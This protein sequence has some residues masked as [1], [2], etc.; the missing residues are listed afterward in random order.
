M[1]CEHCRQDVPATASHEDGE[2]RCPQC[3]EGLA[4]D[5]ARPSDDGL[6]DRQQPAAA[7]DSLLDDGW[8][9]DQQLQHIERVLKAG[10]VGGRSSQAVGPQEVTRFDPAH[11]G[12]AAW[13]PSLAAKPARNR[14]PDSGRSSSALGVLAWMALSL[15]TTTFACGGML[16][17]WSLVAERQ[18]LWNLGLPIALGGQIVLLIGL[19]LQLDRLWHDNRHAAAKLDQVD[20]QLHDL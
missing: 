2:F 9:L 4:A 12:P 8:E 20:E 15:G 1:W 16:L 17:G 19:V 11:A 6:A 7:A 18:E 10:E 3:G 5:S 14:K 13:H